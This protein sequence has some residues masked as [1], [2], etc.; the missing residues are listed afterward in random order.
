M[1][2][3]TQSNKITID[4]EI[5]LSLKDISVKIDG[6]TIIKDISFDLKKNEVAALFGF[7]GSG[8]STLLKSISGRY[9]SDSFKTEGSVRYYSENKDYEVWSK[10]FQSNPLFYSRIAYLDQSPALF[11]YSVYENIAIPVRYHMKNKGLSFSRTD[12]DE[13]I[14]KRLKNAA[15]WDEVKDMLDKSP[16][17]LS[18]GQKQR[19]CLARALAIDPD[20]LLLDEPAAHLDH[21]SMERLEEAIE[22][23]KI[24]TSMIIVT[25]NMQQAIRISETALFMKDGKIIEN[26]ETGKI[27][28][29][30]QQKI[31]ENYIVGRF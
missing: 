9:A 17:S 21:F 31:T 16:E 13:V 20:I 2:K 18:T 26:A 6:N 24:G 5:V 14:E 3:Q 30:P 29:T 19:I 15:V 28:T 22:N 10:S 27:F 7:S 8:K 25:H 1:N 12:I 23:S 11:P 4:K